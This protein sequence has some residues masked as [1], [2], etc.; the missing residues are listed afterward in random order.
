MGLVM[1]AAEGPTK[2]LGE[3]NVSSSPRPA[4]NSQ[5]HPWRPLR[6]GKPRKWQCETGTWALR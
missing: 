6:R 4:K 3:A 5:T 2:A 1:A